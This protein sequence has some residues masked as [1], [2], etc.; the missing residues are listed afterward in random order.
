MT[1]DHD[2]YRA[3]NVLILQ[4]G[5]AATIHATVCHDQLL[6][7][8]DVRGVTFWRRMMQAIPVLLT[9]ERTAD[10]APH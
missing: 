4:L 2:I 1:S 10:A 3:A 7:D 5:A 9:R 8:G 6:A